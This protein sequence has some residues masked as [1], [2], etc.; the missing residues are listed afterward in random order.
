MKKLIW[1]LAIAS[2]IACNES[3]T[4]KNQ[5][6]TEQLIDRAKETHKTIDDLNNELSN[7]ITHCI[8]KL[9]EQTAKDIITNYDWNMLCLDSV[10]SIT[11][12]VA[13]ILAS[14]QGKLISLLNI[15][16]ISPEAAKNISQFHGSIRVSL[17]VNKELIKATT[18][19][20]GDVNNSKSHN[21]P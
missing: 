12:E 10:R 1:V 9:D 21:M 7:W 13:T 5:R 20:S 11:P 8:K 3:E 19:I 17:H 2:L 4:I 15:Q 14:F 18:W 6:Q 16:D